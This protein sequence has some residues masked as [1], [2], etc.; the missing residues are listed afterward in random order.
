MV[1][2][3]ASELELLRSLIDATRL[4]ILIVDSHGQVQRV[5]RAVEEATGLSQEAMRMPIWRLAT[6]PDERLLLKE[7]FAPLDEAARP[8]GVL[9]HLMSAGAT[10]HVVDWTVKVLRDGETAPIV[11][12]MGVDLSQRFAAEAHLREAEELRHLVL[13]RIPAV[14]WMTDADLRFTF[15]AGGGLASLGLGAGEVAVLGT[16]LYAYFHTKDPSHPGIAP[17]LR[18]LRGEPTTSEMQWNDRVFQARVEALRDRDRRI[19]GCIGTALDITELTRAKRS[20][21]QSEERIRCL[22]DAN[23]I[24]VALWDTEGRIRDA[25]EAFLDLVGYTRDEVLSGAISWREMTPPELRHLDERALAEVAATGKCTPY[26]KEYIAKD[27]TRVPVLIGAASFGGQEPGRREGVAF[28]VDLREQVRLRAA[29]DALLESEQRARIDTELANTR[30]SLLVNGSRRLARTMT[31][32]E[33]LTALAELVV[34]AL[35]DW[36]YVAHRGRNGGPWLVAS[37]C[38]DPNKRALLRRLHDCKPDPEAPEGA[39]R[40]FRTGELAAY[41]NITPAELLS[42]GVSW[43]IVGTR[44]PE[45]LG[46]IR[47]LGMRSLLCVPIRGRAGVEAVAMLVASTD[48]HRYGRDDVILAEDLAGRAA[49]ALENGRLLAEA[50]ESI[51]ARDTFLSVAAHELRTPLTSLMLRVGMLKKAAEAG[52]LQPDAALTGIL[53]AEAQAQRLS[54]L[55]DNLLDVARAGSGRMTIFADRVDMAEVVRD[56]AASMAPDCD[57]AGCALEVAAS[58]TVI[59]RWDRGRM[60]QVVRNLLSN[61]IKFGPRHPI[62]VRLEATADNVRISI[63]DHGIGLSPED[64]TR[65]FDRFERAVSPRH[66]GGLGLGL[67]ISA[68]ILRAHGGSLSVES[69]PGRGAC[70][71]VDVPRDPPSN[72]V[73]APVISPRAPERPVLQLA[74]NR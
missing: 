73:P 74:G 50:L 69:Q 16:S 8:D 36:S 6:L 61:A 44:D 53:S 55:V 71:F 10:P 31:I 49:V 23:V 66:Y 11:A 3:S 1:E 5:N 60:E 25:N 34:P 68:Q 9:F 32:G 70:F 52:A 18:A 42:A 19:M 58:G 41:E 54:T 33:T 4:F 40:V 51:Q 7:R 21:K 45:H 17:H 47:E 27:G 2:T 48:P 35:A 59:G 15:S 46:I 37:A 20:Q 64:Q 26:E 57:R 12:F 39:P 24:G 30:L 63:R 22:V 13:D 65:I 56:T 43:P 62:E 72:D 14:V 29:R 28:T 38:G 67:Y